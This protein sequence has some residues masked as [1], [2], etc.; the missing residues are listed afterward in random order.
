MHLTA[1]W[2]R[3]TG[4]PC[5]PNQ[6]YAAKQAKP[7]V[8]SKNFFTKTQ[9]FLTLAKTC[10]ISEEDKVQ[11]SQNTGKHM[12]DW[13][14]CKIA[15]GIKN[16]AEDY[17]KVVPRNQQTYEE[18]YKAFNEIQHSRAENPQNSQERV[19]L[20][21]KCSKEPEEVLQASASVLG[22]RG[23]FTV[24]G[25]GKIN[26]IIFNGWTAIWRLYFVQCLILVLNKNYVKTKF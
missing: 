8:F 19:V 9:T 11:D 20:H 18:L 13:E 1:S 23:Y 6:N 4:I 21:Q 3:K 2:L 7:K 26:R 10:K 24:S 14:K 5:L 15:A 22:T 25:N 17:L 12:Q 16:F